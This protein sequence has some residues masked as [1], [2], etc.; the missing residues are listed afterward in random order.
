MVGWSKSDCVRVAI[1]S[2]KIN[3]TSSNL[4]FKFEITNQTLEMKKS[5][6]N[7]ETLKTKKERE[8]NKHVVEMKI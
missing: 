4:Y 8:G 2:E 7:I 3:F 1:V 5:K 6:S